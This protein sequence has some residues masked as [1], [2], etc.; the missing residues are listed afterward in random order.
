MAQFH[1]LQEVSAA[2]LAA[3]TLSPDPP[4]RANQ[5]KSTP[6]LAGVLDKQSLSGQW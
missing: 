5:N 6:R 2:F 4:D 1:E 3:D